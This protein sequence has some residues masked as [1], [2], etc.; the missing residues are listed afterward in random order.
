MDGFV[1]ELE[2][3]IRK[4]MLDA[5]PPGVRSG[6]EPLAL[7][8]LAIQ[9]VSW[10]ARLIPAR[11]RRCHRSA[12]LKASRKAV[13]HQAALDAIA[14]K[15]RAGEDLTP[16]LSKGV[17]KPVK[18]DPMMADWRIHHLH[19]STAIGDR[20]FV[21]RSGD[22][23]FAAI[24]P[25]DAYLIGVYPHGAWTRQEIAEILI[26]NWQGAGRFIGMSGVK[27]NGPNL[28]DEERQKARTGGLF[29]PIEVDGK[30]YM[31]PG[32]TTARTSIDASQCAHEL[33]N[34]LGAWRGNTKSKLANVR[35]QMNHAAKGQVHGPL[36]P[37][38]N[39]KGMV[40]VRRGRYFCAIGQLP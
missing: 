31:P 26:R 16:H 35:Q 18:D 21:K 37:A 24:D 6:L 12:E 7:S 14:A 36:K 17:A 32:I 19:L 40:G 28:T 25:D 15:I 4:Y 33:T 23:L 2:V 8:D 20:G 34:L 22:L 38:V 3:A 11:P 5:M 30:L 13:E 1:E 10:R 39:D 9:Y 29:M 27:L